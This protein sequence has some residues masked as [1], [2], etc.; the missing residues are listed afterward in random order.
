SNLAALVAA[1]ANRTSPHS[2]LAATAGI[3]AS[4]A[5]AHTIAL[6]I[7]MTPNPS[8]EPTAKNLRFLA[9]AHIKRWSVFPGS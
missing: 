5:T 4:T 3:P 7:Q 9:S 6:S 1:M 8:I 2:R